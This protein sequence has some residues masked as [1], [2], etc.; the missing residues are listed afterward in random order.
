M[1][2]MSD[3]QKPESRK[4]FYAR[5]R[6]KNLAILGCIIAFFVLFYLITILKMG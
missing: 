6:G 5:K 1:S 4:E 3:D 2:T